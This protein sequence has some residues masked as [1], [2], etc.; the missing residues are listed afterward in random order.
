MHSVGPTI[1]NAS[2][3][4]LKIRFHS[5]PRT[6]KT[7]ASS[8]KNRSQVASTNSSATPDSAGADVENDAII[9]TMLEIAWIDRVAAGLFYHG[10]FFDATSGEERS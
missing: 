8:K 3:A 4:L 6:I 5:S 9:G 2:Y 1:D 10:V 7:M